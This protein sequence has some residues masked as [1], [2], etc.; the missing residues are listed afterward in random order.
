M[1]AQFA[2]QSSKAS[3]ELQKRVWHRISSKNQD[4]DQRDPKKDIGNERW[5]ES[6]IDFEV[7]KID[8]DACHHWKGCCLSHPAELYHQLGITLK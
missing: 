1:R 3:D 6:W 4:C 8:S 7:S 5:L 2:D